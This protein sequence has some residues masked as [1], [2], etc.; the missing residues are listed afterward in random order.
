MKYRQVILRQ[1]W[2]RVR[3]LNPTTLEPVAENETGLLAFFDLANLGS[4]CHVLTEDIGRVIGGK[5]SSR[6]S[7]S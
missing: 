1:P 2:L 6:G 3:A 5:G 4:V 7:F